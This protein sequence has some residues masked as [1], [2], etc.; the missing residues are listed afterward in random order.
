MSDARYR[1]VA[2]R[3]LAPLVEH[4]PDGPDWDELMADGV[5]MAA[6]RRGATSPW[7]VGSSVI[8]IVLLVALALV[9]AP[10][11]PVGDPS[12]GPV[13]DA[14]TAAEEAETWWSLVI[15][16]DIDA[17][18][19]RAHPD[20]EFNFA[21]LVEIGSSLGFDV[22]ISVD[23]EQFGSDQQ[24]MLCYLLDG[25]RSDQ[26]GAVVFRLHDGEWR[27]WEI[28]PGT[29][30]CVADG[31]T[32]TLPEMDLDAPP[33]LSQPTGSQVYL[34]TD[35]ELTVVDI[36]SALIEV[37][38]LAELAPGDPL[39][40][41]IRRGDGFVFYG[42]TEDGPAV[43]SW[44]PVEPMI[45]ALIDE[46]SFFIP[47]AVEDRIWMVSV[48]RL[49]D[50]VESVRELT[51]DGRVTV[52]DVAPPNGRRPIAAVAAGLVFQA[53]EMLEVWDPL[54]QQSV[55]TLP[56]PFAVAT[57]ANRVVSCSRC[58]QLL[59]SDLDT[60]TQRTIDLPPEVGFVDAFGGA[61]SPNGGYM[62][63]PAYLNDAQQST[64]DTDVGVV[65]VDFDAGTA[66]LVPGMSHGLNSYRQISWSSDGE[67]LFYNVGGLL[68]E[69]GRLFAYRPQDLTAYRVPIT[70]DRQHYGMAAD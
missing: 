56:G 26:S 47:S 68:L 55:T 5:V 2:R 4:V 11:E 22:E 38:E 13:F 63:V 54:T 57:W 50:S 15:S 30:R 33:V 19:E 69:T 16:G 70:L 52:P 40:R 3:A 18:I 58:D 51:V 34:S 35:D 41:L 45:P 61:F 29:E 20:E 23:R 49:S 17:A 65:L 48:G 37:H 8:A 46:A 7:L 53:E 10:S 42:R 39:Y 66:S 6:P 12:P 67:W 14:A 36:D 60:G 62:A 44:D 1:N 25:R 32:T 28:R 59:L 27:I 21:G 9:L 64:Q 31:P 24:P 43:F